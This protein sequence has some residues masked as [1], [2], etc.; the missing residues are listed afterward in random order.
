MVFG[1]LYHKLLA[2]GAVALL[3]ANW[4]CKPLWRGQGNEA[5]DQRP[6]E[7]QALLESEGTGQGKEQKHPE[8]EQPASASYQAPEPERSDPAVAAEDVI[9][10]SSAPANPGVGAASTASAK[11]AAKA[12]AAA[13]GDSPG[14][15]STSAAPVAGGTPAE[16]VNEDYLRSLLDLEFGPPKFAVRKS[17][18]PEPAA[19]APKAAA[20]A[21]AASA[22][23]AAKAAA[24]KAAAPTAPPAAAPQP[25]AAAAAAPASAGANA[26]PGNR[27]SIDE[28][29]D[30]QFGPPKFAV[31]K[32]ASPG[33]APGRAAAAAGGAIAGA[34]GASAAAAG[35]AAAGATAA[36]SG[37]GAAAAPAA[38][39]GAHHHPLPD[40]EV[41]AA[42]VA[43][44]ARSAAG[45][46]DVDMDPTPAAAA[47]VA[48]GAGAIAVGSKRHHEDD[49]G[50][51]AAAAGAAAAAEEEAGGSGGLLTLTFTVS[52]GPVAGKLCVADDPAM[53][54]KVGRTPECQPFQLLDAEV[55]GRHASLRWDGA[56]RA[57]K[58]HDAG[59]LNGTKV[60]GAVISRDYKVPGDEVVLRDGDELEFGSVT[61]GRVRLTVSGPAGAGG[62][63]AAAQAAKRRHSEDTATG[64]PSGAVTLSDLAAADGAAHPAAASAA[65]SLA[66]GSLA[67]GLGGGLPA[68]LA[69]VEL[70]ELGARL[71]VHN[72]LGADHKRLGQGCEDVPAW[73]LPFA[74]YAAAGLL[75]VFDGHHGSKA[76]HQAKEH[77]PAVLR[78]KLLLRDGRTPPPLAAPPPPHQPRRPD[79][80]EEEE[81]EEGYNDEDED[82][83]GQQQATS[84]GSKAGKAKREAAKPATPPPVEAAAPEALPADLLPPPPAGPPLPPLLAGRDVASQ[85]ALLRDAFL[86]C[87]RYMS[88]EEGCTATVVLLQAPAARA[89]AAAGG[90]SS[91]SGAAA[92]AGAGAAPGAAGWSMQSANVGDSSAVLVNFTRGTHAKLSEDHR[93]A[94]SVSERQRLAQRGH[95]VRTRL[96]GLNISRMLGD[97]FLKEEDLGF[98]AEPHVSGVAQ[99]GPGESAVLIVASDGLWDVLP[100]PH[101]GKLL[102]Q[103]AAKPSPRL[104]A[105]PRDAAAAPAPPPPAG[106]LSCQAVADLLLAQALVLRSKDDITIAVLEMGP[107]LL[108]R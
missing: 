25:K 14:P 56:A 105:S 60:N 61:R 101:A 11:S 63:Q 46:A 108:Q 91:S 23:P 83:D 17:D 69:V 84:S 67:G 97:R 36:N 78:H 77:M 81:L 50:A 40:A 85:K 26:N 9:L 53:E 55:S 71:C 35:A 73:E 103:E 33:H 57:W 32:P 79:E 38:A 20:A 6:P 54:Y 72:R 3:V 94:S 86:T 51:G 62:R 42:L 30:Q 58:L 100:E 106:A 21:P 43:A 41:A 95:T 44:A 34:A 89:G 93:I 88:M 74:P 107:H 98:L 76:A 92:G 10:E 90:G 2:A 8:A 27:M 22:A 48:A 104:A 37:G 18:K 65:G 99:V 87:D 15:S 49:A 4:L 31:Q 29:L 80:E 45:E 70:P 24:P 82:A 5:S 64:L 68:P 1:G 12:T 52:A 96:Y 47:G 7:Q 28:L 19:A 75:A 66:L 59:S 13:A 16:P 102:L 39:A